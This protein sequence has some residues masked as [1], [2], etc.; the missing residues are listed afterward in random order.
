MF[1]ISLITAKA[2]RSRNKGTTYF[3]KS[4]KKMKKKNIFHIKNNA[5]SNKYH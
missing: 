5:M 1:Y 3:Q 4:Q 2:A